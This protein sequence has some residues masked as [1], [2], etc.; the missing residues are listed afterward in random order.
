MKVEQIKV[1]VP[2]TGKG[3]RLSVLGQT[4][5]PFPVKRLFWISEVPNPWERRGDHAHLTNHQVLV[6]VC[7][8]F[9]AYIKGGWGRAEMWL[10]RGGLA[11]HVPTFNWLTLSQFTADAVCLVLC[12][13]QY[14]AES[15][16][17]DYHEFKKLVGAV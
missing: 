13:E 3:G 14:K 17:R 10:E 5:L 6:P 16:I 15:Y 11:L 12:S 9:H 7:G 4:S 8:R 1:D 2:Y